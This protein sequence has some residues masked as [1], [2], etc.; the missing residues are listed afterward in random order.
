MGRCD[1]DPEACFAEH[2][3]RRLDGCRAGA[4][5]WRACC[6]THDDHKP[7]L[8]ISPGKGLR[9]VW[10]CHARPGCDAGDIRRA[11]LARGVDERCLG[12][13]GRRPAPSSSRDRQVLAD[14]EQIITDDHANPQRMRLLIGMALWECGR[15]EAATKLGISRATM[16]RAVSPV[17]Q[18]PRN[19][20]SH[21]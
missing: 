19:R 14:I 4:G 6:P 8:T 1:L 16:Y 2:I 20:Q 7:S 11:L 3:A 13:Y 10:T 17:R 5:G 18:T 15:Q 9:F 21:G 12:S